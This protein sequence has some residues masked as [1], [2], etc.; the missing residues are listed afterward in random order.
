MLG[1]ALR[2]VAKTALSQRYRFAALAGSIAL[3]SSLLVVLAVLY[4][5]ASS[6]LAVELSG[7]PN[8]VVEPKK[9]PAGVPVAEL[10]ADQVPA[11]KAREHFWR[12]NIQ[13]AAPVLLA[14]GNAGGRELRLAG[15]WFRREVPSEN[16]SYPFG[17]LEFRGWSYTGE[18]PGEGMVVLGAAVGIAQPGDAV[19]IETANSTRT[20]RVAGVLETGSYWDSY[21]FLSLEELQQMLGRTD[22]DLVLVGALIKPRDELAVR[23]ELYG[24]EALSPE[25][26][27]AWYCSPYA[28]AI[29]YTIAEVVPNSSVRVLRRVTGVQEEL[30]RASSAAFLV[31]FAVSALVAVFSIL[32]AVRMYVSAKRREL[33]IQRA[34]GASEARVAVQLGMEVLAASLLAALLAYPVS[35]TV[36]EAIS[37]SV[38]GVEL[39]SGLELLVLSLAMPPAASL[40]ALFFLRKELSRELVEVLR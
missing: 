18:P 20:F 26:F 40:V 6:L 8:L 14:E 9:T 21:V 39:S 3:A 31:L 35:G 28:S 1:F 12:N 24:P 36:A 30:L 34:I 37:R 5:N 16:G 27:E 19:E 23:A 22:I 7:V 11:L 15:T 38:F 33:G 10:S 13:N 25:E 29:A 2:L 32:S 17:V 4:L